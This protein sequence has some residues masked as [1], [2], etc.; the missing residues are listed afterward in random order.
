[1]Q[2][3]ETVKVAPIGPPA[4]ANL[5][6]MWMHGGRTT[7]LLASCPGPQHTL[8]CSQANGPHDM[9]VGVKLYW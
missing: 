4:G 8:V 1:M 2:A 7:L 5:Y 9:Q 3:L 6:A